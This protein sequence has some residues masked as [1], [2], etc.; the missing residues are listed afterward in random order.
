VI[1]V[2]RHQRVSRLVYRHRVLFVRQECVGGIPPA[3]QDAI[4]SGIGPLRRKVDGENYAALA[5]PGRSADIAP[6]RTRW[7]VSYRG[8]TAPHPDELNVIEPPSVPTTVD[9]TVTT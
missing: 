7:A 9:G 4:A 3:E 8:L 6:S 5:E 2:H 1:R